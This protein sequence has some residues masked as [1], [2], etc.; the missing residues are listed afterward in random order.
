MSNQVSVFS[1]RTAAPGRPTECR[2]GVLAL[3]D[4]FVLESGADLRDA[5]LAWECTGPGGAPLAIVLGGISAHRRCTAADGSGW[6]QGQCGP[7]RALD[8]ERFRLLSVDWL[9]GCDGSTG[10][11]GAGFPCIS[12]ADQARAILLLL[13]RLGVRQVHLLA[14]ASYGGAVAQHLAALLGRRLR[15]LVVF[16]AAHK[17]AQFALALRDIQRAILDLGNDAPRALALTRAL[18]VLGYRT[19]EG[20]EQRFAGAG[21]DVVAWLAH[22]GEKFAA[23]FNAESYRCLSV[24]LDSHRIDPRTILAPTTLFAVREDLLVPLSLAREFA[25]ACG[26]GCEFV[27][28]SSPFGHDAFLKEEPAVAAVLRAAIEAAA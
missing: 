14:G 28:I 17:P 27:E 16:S 2:Q 23:R 15:R 8:S 3:P 7:G 4:P 12:S 26:G 9:G 21:A 13:N 11:G 18:A 25:A 10:P 1:N 19:P 24:S 22:H 6:W 5:H 20:V